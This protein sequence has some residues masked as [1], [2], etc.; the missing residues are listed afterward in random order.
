VRI[1]QGQRLWC[2]GLLVCVL[3]GAAC[4][5]SDSDDEWQRVDLQT[6]IRS[7]DGELNPTD[8]PVHVDVYVV[9]R[10]R[11]ARRSD[12]EPQGQNTIELTGRTGQQRFQWPTR[13]FAG[14]WCEIVDL[15]GD[16]AREFVFIDGSSA[17]VVSY[18]GG[19]FQFRESKDALTA[20]QPIRLLDF[21]RDGRLDFVT[22]APATIIE[23]STTRSA[24]ALANWDHQRGFDR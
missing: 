11:M 21:D 1:V 3:I 13:T 19:A 22:W 4:D 2:A 5:S 14:G 15:D 9:G 23:P 24:V 20:K 16:G 12:P 8:G 7:F 10:S 18:Q 17:R 6:H